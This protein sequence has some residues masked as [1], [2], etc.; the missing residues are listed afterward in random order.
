MDR[1]EARRTLGLADPVRP[2]A[3]KRAY[4]RL[5][6]ELHPDAGGDADRFLRVQQAYD[7]LT[8]ET[9]PPPGRSPQRRSAGVD[10]RW[11]ETPAAWH[12]GEVELGGVDLAVDV[13]A[14]PATRVDLDM[15][16]TL[17]ARGEPV[18]E[19]TLRSRHPGSR[20]HR[21]IAWLEPD[22]LATLTVR[23]APD[24]P[25]P[26]HDVDVVLRAPGGRGRRLLDDVRTANGWTRGRGSESTR[27]ERRLRPSR[28]PHDTAVRTARLVADGLAEI[29]WPL[30]EWFLLGSDHAPPT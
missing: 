15:L 2:E 17:L 19:V 25:R 26:G 8:A 28:R 12:E 13:P 10:E 30:H 5:A 3:V 20:L 4:R 18:G 1:R 6:R 7:V 29:G 27:L 16:A 23:P 11:W 22:L 24:G 14:A 21:M 9:V